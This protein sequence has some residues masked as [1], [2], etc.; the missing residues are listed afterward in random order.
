MMRVD[1]F[2][3]V[4]AARSGLRLQIDAAEAGIGCRIFRFH[5]AQSNRG[6][7]QPPAGEGLGS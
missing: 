5:G 3:C 4:R 7:L 2:R 6:A 1:E